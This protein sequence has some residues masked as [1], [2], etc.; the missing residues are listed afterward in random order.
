MRDYGLKERRV[1]LHGQ[2]GSGGVW[3]FVLAVAWLA[4]VYLFPN[5]IPI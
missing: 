1:F 5:A 3:L 4:F 2:R